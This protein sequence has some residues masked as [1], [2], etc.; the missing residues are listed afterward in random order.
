MLRTVIYIGARKKKKLPQEVRVKCECDKELKNYLGIK[1]Q[2]ALRI[3]FYIRL[4]L[5]EKGTSMNT[6]LCIVIL[7]SINW[8]RNM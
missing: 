6:R 7:N 2:S 8:R 5:H 1:V 3:M 4:H